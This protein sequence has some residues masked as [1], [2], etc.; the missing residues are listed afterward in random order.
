[1]HIEGKPAREVYTSLD[2]MSAYFEADGQLFLLSVWNVSAAHY[3]VLLRLTP[4]EAARCREGGA[5]YMTTFAR[6]AINNAR[7]LDRRVRDY[8]L[9][10]G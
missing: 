9:P 7:L 4:E 8:A 10:P 3:E 6:A 5:A 2:W 1:M